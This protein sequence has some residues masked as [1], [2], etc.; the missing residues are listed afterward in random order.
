[1]C[2]DT[3]AA[4]RVASEV[5]AIDPAC[6]RPILMR[7]TH[8]S[9]PRPSRPPK[10]PRSSAVCRQTRKRNLL[11]ALADEEECIG[12]TVIHSLKL[13]ICSWSSRV[14]LCRSRQRKNCAGKRKCRQRRRDYPAV[15]TLLLSNN[16]TSSAALRHALKGRPTPGQ[17]RRAQATPPRSRP[18]TMAADRRTLGSNSLELWPKRAAMWRGR[19]TMVAAVRAW[20]RVAAPHERLHMSAMLINLASWFLTCGERAGSGC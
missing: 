14:V 5:T 17:Q 18:R 19:G 2:E 9:R 6:V 12:Y 3:R 13:L 1:V 20:R 4:T 16:P 11:G 15:K 7:L 10:A 8:R